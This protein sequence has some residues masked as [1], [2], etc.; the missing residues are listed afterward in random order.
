MFDAS[1]RFFGPSVLFHD[2]RFFLRREIVLDVEELADLLDALALNHGG[3][4]GARELKQGFDIEVIGGHDN[5][6][7]HLLVD[8]DEVGVPSINNL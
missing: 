2:L 1:E 6:E 7:E 8:I 4:L 5:F 3:N